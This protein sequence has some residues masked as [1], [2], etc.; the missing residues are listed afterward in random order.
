M[1]VANE[2]EFFERTCG[3]RAPFQLALAPYYSLVI[4]EVTLSQIRKTGGDLKEM[5]TRVQIRFFFPE[6]KPAGCFPL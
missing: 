4:L 2:N 6:K 1:Q 5:Y 3:K